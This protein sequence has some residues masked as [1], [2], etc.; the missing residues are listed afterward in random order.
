[1]SLKNPSFE[2]IDLWDNKAN[3]V[4]SLDVSVSIKR[5]S[6]VKKLMTLLIPSSVLSKTLYLLDRKDNLSI[7]LF[8]LN[9]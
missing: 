9:N 2:L 4:L 8:I 7:L 5:D 1:M 6:S 3:I